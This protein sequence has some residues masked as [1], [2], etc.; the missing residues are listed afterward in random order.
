MTLL[1]GDVILE[2]GEG[3]QGGR[4][5]KFPRVYFPPSHSFLKVVPQ[6]AY[7]YR[8]FFVIKYRVL[9]ETFVG[10]VI[11]ICGIIFS[12]AP[13]MTGEERW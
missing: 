12:I 10:Q 3:S 6:K 13:G 9:S 8:P 7:P 2:R 5:A 4:E 1:P 11:D